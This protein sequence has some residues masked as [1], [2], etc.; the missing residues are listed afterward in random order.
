MKKTLNFLLFTIILVSCG[1]NRSIS[2]INQKRDQSKGN[3]IVLQKVLNDSRCP[4]GVQCIWEGEVTIQ[5]AYFEKGQMKE[6]KQFTLR[7]NDQE[8][9]VQWFRSHLPKSQK[10]L[11][12]VSILPTKVEGKKINSLEYVIVLGY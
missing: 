12:T 10:V 4:Q 1:S 6:E 3:E 11:Q 9:V 8:E 7:Q 2:Q 5:V